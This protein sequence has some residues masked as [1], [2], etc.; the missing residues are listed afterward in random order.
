MQSWIV[1]LLI[2]EEARLLRAVGV[3][4]LPRLLW[5]WLLRPRPMREEPEEPDRQSSPL[6]TRPEGRAYPFSDCSRAAGLTE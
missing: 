5:A 2:I 6:D 4:N 1:L 3:V